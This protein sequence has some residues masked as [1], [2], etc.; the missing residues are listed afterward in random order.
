MNVHPDGEYSDWK[1]H[2]RRTTML[3]SG[4]KRA[5][6][7]FK[8]NSGPGGSR[9]GSSRAVDCHRTK[10]NDVTR[11]LGLSRNFNFLLAL[12]ALIMYIDDILKETPCPAQ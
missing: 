10:R 4:N 8:L 7:N 2:E 12:Q 3:D 11:R 6:E 5:K 1:T 9:K